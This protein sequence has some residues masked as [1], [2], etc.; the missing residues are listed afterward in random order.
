MRKLIT[1]LALI[2]LGLFTFG[3]VA[4]AT[5]FLQDGDA[6]AEVAE[7]DTIGDSTQ[8][9][10]AAAQGASEYVT[11]MLADTLGVPEGIAAIIGKAIVF[12]LILIIFKIIAT[13]AA[14][15][16]GGALSKS[17]LKPTQLLLD[18]I[19]GTTSKL[20]MAIGFIMALAV[21]GL[22]VAPLLAGLGVLGFVVG[23]ALQDTLGNFA[24]G[25]MIL[26]YRPYDVGDVVTA[27]GVTGSVKSMN[28]VST[29][30]GTPDNQVQIV[31]NGQ[32]WGGVITNVTANE[33]RRVDLVA[34]IGYDDDIEKAEAVL[35]R[36]VKSHDKVLAEP[37]PVIKVHELADSSVNLIVRPWT[38]TSDYWAVY[39]DLTRAIKMEFDKEAISIPFPQRDVHLHK[40]EG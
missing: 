32:I 29:T 12:V 28:L 30:L 15:I 40:V 10:S 36:I 1:A 11:S 18:F 22:D 20:I 37:A 6:A 34:G 16:V 35:E 4:H 3:P 2:A 39:W 19:K 7:P 14:S 17:K 5:T 31:P 26:L 24:A 38:K 13:I 25:V 9:A 8:A 27:G 23:F 21:V 33:T